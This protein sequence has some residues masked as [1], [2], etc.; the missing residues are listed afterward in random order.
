MEC[1][2]C[3]GI[4][5]NEATLTKHKSSLHGP[6][7]VKKCVTCEKSLGANNFARHAQTC[8]QKQSASPSVGEKEVNVPKREEPKPRYCAAVPEKQKNFKLPEKLPP[9]KKEFHI[10]LKRLTPEQIQYFQTGA[11]NIA[12]SPSGDKKLDD[13]NVPVRL[14]T[15]ERHVPLQRL[16]PRQLLY[17]N[18]GAGNTVGTNAPDNSQGADGVNALVQRLESE[19][20]KERGS[21]EQSD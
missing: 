21:K 19:E 11:V 6:N 16:T 8:T 9:R 18:T 5:K 17:C 13:S 1:T 12:M 7:R 3:G 4:F 14:Y 2:L 15:K 20:K 10:P